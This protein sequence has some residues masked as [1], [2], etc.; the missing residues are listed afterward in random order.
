[1]TA[2]VQRVEIVNARPNHVLH[3]LL[4]VIT[5]GLWIPVWLIIAGRSNLSRVERGSNDFWSRVLI[6]LIF[7]AIGFYL[8]K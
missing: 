8:L 4:S 7:A 6:L 1:M 2:P 3:L 5:C